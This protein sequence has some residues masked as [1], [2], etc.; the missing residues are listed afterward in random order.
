MQMILGDHENSEHSLKRKSPNALS[1][2]QRREGGEQ[3]QYP[4]DTRRGCMENVSLN[5]GAN[6]KRYVYTVLHNAM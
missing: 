5:T 1:T 6:Y 2:A 4:L 3:E